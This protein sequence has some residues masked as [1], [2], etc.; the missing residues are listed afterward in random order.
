[1]VSKEGV[2]SNRSIALV[3]KALANLSTRS[4]AG[5]APHLFNLPMKEVVTLALSES[6]GMIRAHIHFANCGNSI[7]VAMHT[8]KIN[9]RMMAN[10]TDVGPSTFL[11]KVIILR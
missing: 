6:S 5:A 7:I 11:R 2:T 9:D 10:S 1:M 3:H 8:A 4:I